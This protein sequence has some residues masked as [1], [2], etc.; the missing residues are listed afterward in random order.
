MRIVRQIKA[1]GILKQRN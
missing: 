1:V